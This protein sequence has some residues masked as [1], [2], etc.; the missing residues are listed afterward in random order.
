MVI[1]ACGG[2]HYSG[3]ELEL[4][5]RN[6]NGTTLLHDIQV[7]VAV[8]FDLVTQ[9]FTAKGKFPDLHTALAHIVLEDRA[10]TSIAF[11]RRT[12]ARRTRMRLEHEPP[13]DLSS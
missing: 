8:M 3:R 2:A 12:N 4:L 7:R 5:E 11:V 6:D 10:T 9:E 1:E 13:P